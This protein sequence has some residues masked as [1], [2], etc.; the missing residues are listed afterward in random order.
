MCVIDKHKPVS[1]VNSYAKNSLPFNFA[2]AS[3]DITDFLVIQSIALFYY[4]TLNH[5]S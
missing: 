5:Q 2:A 3:N 4:A 1:K